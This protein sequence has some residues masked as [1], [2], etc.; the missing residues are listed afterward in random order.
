MAGAVA[1]RCPGERHSPGSAPGLRGLSPSHPDAHHWRRFNLL[2]RSLY[3]FAPHQLDRGGVRLHYLDEGAGDVVVCV[4]GNPT[5]SFFYRDVVAALR[6]SH[7]VLVPDH[8]GC[9]LSDRPDDS[10]YDYRL[11]SRIDDLEALIDHAAPGQKVTLIVHDWGG[12]IGL[13]WAVRHPERLAKL[14]V[15]NTAAFSLPAGKSL[16]WQLWVVRNTPLGPFLV[17]GLNAFSRGLVSTCS[18]KHLPPEVR[19]GYLAPYDSWANRLA[20]L[21]FVQDIPLRPGDPS[22][23]TV[24]D[25]QAGLSKLASVPTLICWGEKDF[26]FDLDFLAEWQRRMP[27]AVVRRFADAGH[28]VLED[29]GDRIIPLIRDFLGARP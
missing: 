23:D 18:V 26:V 22:W 3:P 7:R 5:W 20:V 2:S 17:R 16:P 8:V 11:R 24:Q 9:G 28:L 15:L 4:H 21:R 19:E 29:A 6:G 1:L 12:M 13:G 27:Y 14:V 25:V 10:R